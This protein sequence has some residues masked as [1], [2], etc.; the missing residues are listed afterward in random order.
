MSDN[1]IDVH[2][3]DGKL[4]IRLDQNFSK[5]EKLKQIGTFVPKIKSS[6]AGSTIYLIGNALITDSK[7]NYD[8]KNNI[9]ASDIL[10]NILSR[11]YDKILNL[12]E[13]QLIDIYNL[14]QCPQGRTTRLWQI[15]QLLI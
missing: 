2:Q 5:E 14:G 10:A 7:D 3:Y 8:D 6:V 9:D 1:F 11:D 13:E 12:L 4:T 15:L